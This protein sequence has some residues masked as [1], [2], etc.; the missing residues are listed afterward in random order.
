LDAR[1]LK[2][3]HRVDWPGTV[4]ADR[5]MLRQAIF[6]LLRNAIQFAP[7][8]GS[9]TIVVKQGEHGRARIE[10]ADGGPGV[11]PDKVDS[12]FTPYFTTRPDGTGLGL[13]IVRRIAAAHGW[14]SGYT[15][16]AG[17][18]SVFWLDGIHG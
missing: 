10:V 16:R 3:A 17:G 7:P 18:G 9:V 14:Q 6:N 13:A 11:P 15:P 2:L 8:Q 1:G 4:R 12:L 5:E